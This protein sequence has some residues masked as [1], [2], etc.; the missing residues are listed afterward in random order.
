MRQDAIREL[1]EILSEHAVDVLNIQLNVLLKG[2][3]ALT[4]DKEK[5][6]RRESLKALNLVLS[7]VSKDQLLPFSNILVSY[8]TCA[9]TH[10]DQ[11]IMEDSLLFLDILIQHCSS[12]LA[13]NSYKILP[14][15]L[16]MISK[17]RSQAQ[18]GRQLTTNLNSKNTSM[19]WRIKVLNSLQ[20]FLFAIVQNKKNSRSISSIH[21][22]NVHHIKDENGHFPVY[23][24]T[25]LQPYLIDF[26]TSD[27]NKQTNKAL[28][29]GE[30]Q[31]YIDSLMPLM[32]DSWLEVSPKK[33]VSS[34][35]QLPISDEAGSLLKCITSIIQSII[36]YIE[37][38]E[39]DSKTS[40][41]SS[42][43]KNKFQN[44]FI[45]NLIMEFP[46]VPQKSGSRLKKSQEDLLTSGDC[47]EQNLTLCYIYIWFTTIPG[48]PKSDRLDK[49]LSF[50]I[51]QF[52]IGE[53]LYY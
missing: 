1:K 47:L 30:L 37:L 4:L 38:L 25:S 8:L 10:I 19:K 23:S 32:F 50:Q 22:L 13:S 49:N 48:V 15:F 44:I 36:E 3:A 42:W 27:S 41:L 40:L 52:I 46:Y 51:L 26:T 2:I 5:A 43:F 16:D 18:P 21:S 29:S 20:Q 12:F 34:N 33:Q 14:Y 9:M 11:N 45:K 7:P 6:I 28:E 39:N 24:Q 53:T 17:L 31:S 35:A